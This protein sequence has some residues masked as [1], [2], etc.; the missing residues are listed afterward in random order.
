MSKMSRM[1]AGWLVAG[2]SLV[3]IGGLMFACAMSALDW[4]ISALS[5][6]SYTTS[7]YD[8]TEQFEDIR[9]STDTADIGIIPSDGEKIRVECYERNNEAH[10]VTVSE[11]VLEIDV[12]DNRRWYEHVGISFHTPRISVYIPSGTYGALLI[13]TATGDVSISSEMSFRSIDITESTGDVTNRASASE[14]VSI[15][16]NTGNVSVENITAGYVDLR[17]TTGSIKVEGVRCDGDVRANVTTGKATMSDVSGRSVL[18]E[19]STGSISLVSTIASDKITVS[20]TT[21]SIALE[22]CDASELDLK[23]TTGSIRGSILSAKIFDADTST[24]SISVPESAGEGKCRLTTSTGSISIKVKNDG[25][26]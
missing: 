8:I 17:V 13:K 24:G 1:K 15:R 9:I 23:T 18:S 19:G 20:R 26:V 5:T 4:D 22:S 3:L 11:G 2:A 14:G 25:K 7:S 16:T 10:S 6:E 12:E 21:G